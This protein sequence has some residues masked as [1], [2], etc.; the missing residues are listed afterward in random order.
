VIGL[1]VG[2]ASGCLW[3][4]RHQRRKADLPRSPKAQAHYYGRIQRIAANQSRLKAL[5][6]QDAQARAAQAAHRAA[7]KQILQAHPLL[8]NLGYTADPSPS[9]RLLALT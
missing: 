3:R 5:Q 9:G 4:H 2:Y 7:L 6:A 8:S 1:V